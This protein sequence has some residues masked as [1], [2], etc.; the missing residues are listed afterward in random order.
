MFGSG[1]FIHC[2][3]IGVVLL[4]LL[5]VGS[6]SLTESISASCYPSYEEY[7]RRTSAI[8]PWVSGTPKTQGQAEQQHAE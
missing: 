8:V 3:G 7:Q 5:F 2:S 6:T 4:T 1:I